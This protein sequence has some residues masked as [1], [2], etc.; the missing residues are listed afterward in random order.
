MVNSWAD[1][2]R[3]KIAGEVLLAPSET[4]TFEFKVMNMLFRAKQTP[5]V[6]A[7]AVKTGHVPTLCVSGKSEAA[8]DTACDDLGAAAEAVVLPGSHHFDGKYDDVGK[9]VL[10]FIEKRG[11]KRA[12]S[13]SMSLIGS[14]MS[15]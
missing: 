9:V 2:D 8:R 15:S 13:F 6:V 7:T 12:A 3:R 1:P 11:P 10:A 5:Y 4:A 14:V